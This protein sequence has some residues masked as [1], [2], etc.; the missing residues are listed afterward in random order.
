[1]DSWH[2][3]NRQEPGDQVALHWMADVADKAAWITGKRGRKAQVQLKDIQQFGRE[4]CEENINRI[5]SIRL[6]VRIE[7]ARHR[8]NEERERRY[9][10]R[11][12]YRGSGIHRSEV[13]SI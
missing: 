3:S 6:R 9:R 1:M 2:I 8:R 4:P 13:L 5:H 7:D 11:Q 10:R 12:T